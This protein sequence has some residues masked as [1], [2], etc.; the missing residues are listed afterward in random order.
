MR[1]VTQVVDSFNHDLERLD[2]NLDG[3]STY[4]DNI[5][6]QMDAPLH[7]SLRTDPIL[8]Q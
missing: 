5:S 1:K 2:K 7:K 3:V 8:L 6:G 4:I